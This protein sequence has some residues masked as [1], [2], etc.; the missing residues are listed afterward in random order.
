LYKTG[1]L[2]NFLYCVHFSVGP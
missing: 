1:I 2:F